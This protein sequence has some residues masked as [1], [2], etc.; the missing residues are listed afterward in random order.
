[1]LVLV[2]LLLPALADRTG[3]AFLGLTQDVLRPWAVVSMPVILACA[4]IG[5]LRLPLG[6]P[7][8]S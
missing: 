2:P 3:L 8:R 5:V 7:G 6:L 1:M 4:V